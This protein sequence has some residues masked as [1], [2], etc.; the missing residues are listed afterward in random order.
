[1]HAAGLA[2]NPLFESFERALDLASV[3]MNAIVA[4]IINDG[5]PLTCLFASV[6]NKLLTTGV[7]VT[8]IPVP[9]GRQTATAIKAN[10]RNGRQEPPNTKSR[11]ALATSVTQG[12]LGVE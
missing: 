10:A 12:K 1:M 7:H 6:G 8:I 4:P 11:V 5:L 9:V 2:M 3:S